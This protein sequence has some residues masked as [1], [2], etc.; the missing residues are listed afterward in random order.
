MAGLA[1]QNDNCVCHETVCPSCDA[2][3]CF[4]SGDY[5]TEIRVHY[6]GGT[7]KNF[8]RPIQFM[9][10]KCLQCTVDTGDAGGLYLISN[11]EF[12][13]WAKDPLE[14]TWC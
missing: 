9:R 14:I 2:G 5:T 7:P 6:D 11:Y 12:T 3:C 10:I 8:E 4:G 13:N 1:W